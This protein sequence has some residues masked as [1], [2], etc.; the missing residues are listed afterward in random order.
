VFSYYVFSK[1]LYA[2]YDSRLLSIITFI[3]HNADADDLEKCL[4]D[5]QGLPEEERV[6]SEKYDRLQQSLNTIIDDFGMDYIYLVIPDPENGMMVNAISATSAA[7]REAGE[8][9]MPIWDQSDAYS[10]EELDRYASFWNAESI[11]YFEESSEWG[12][13]YT[14]CK[15]LRNTKGETVALICADLSSEYLHKE[16]NTLLIYS[17]LSAIIMIGLFG[18]I[19]IVWFRKKVT[20]PLLALENS[21]RNY[22]SKNK[23]KTDI[24]DFSFDMPYIRTDNEVQSL[25]EAINKM[26]IDM[27]TYAEEI[28]AKEKVIGEKELENLH[29]AEK[30]KAAAEIAELKGS[31]SALLANMPALTFSKDVESGQYIACN[32]AFAD[33]AHKETTEEIIGLTDRDIFSD[34]TADRIAEDDKKVLSMDKPYI[35]YEEVFD[36]EGNSRQVQTTK[37]KFTDPS[38]KLCILA[39]CLD[40]TEMNEIK[41]ESIWAKVAYEEA[42]DAS[43][44]YSNI[45]RALATDY[46]YLYYVDLKTDNFIEY[47]AKRSGEELG[48]ER[49]GE[50][51]FKESHRDAQVLLYADDL[52]AFAH[53]FTKE[54]ILRS[55]KKTGKFTLTYRMLIDNRPVY[56]NM[57]ATMMEN[58]DNHL[59][60]GVNNVDAQMKNQE[61]YERVVEERI[62]YSRITAL[63]GDYICIYTVDPT[64]D[65]FLEY[66]ATA[67]YEGLGLSKGGDNFFDEAIKE[68]ERTVCPEDR[69]R[70][71]N[72]FTKENILK[73]IKKSKIFILNYRLL[74]AGTP[75]YVCL[76]A[77]IVEEKGGPQLIIGVSNIDAQV[78]REEDFRRTLSMEK[79]KVNLDALTGVKNKHAYVDFEEELNKRIDKGDKKLRFAIVVF[80]VNDLKTVN[81]TYGHNRGDLLIKQASQIICDTFKHSPVFRVGGDEFAVIAQDRDYN[82]ID[83]L[84]EKIHECNRQNKGT[85]NAVV[86][87]GM[88][89][90]EAEK[91]VSAV[92]EKADVQMYENKKKLKK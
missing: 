17:I 64:T 84:V 19:I 34:E 35:F 71:A 72:A 4:A 59:I 80:D 36:R 28:I 13:F 70:F 21:T 57:K 65:H 45:A 8:T 20:N 56:Y 48:I 6:T 33:Y 81:D 10:I 82:D 26:A 49:K 2:D 86:A 3:E 90:F 31:V 32:R 25:G 68:S 18:F 1:A 91:N 60:I 42:R 78:K 92:F 88:A 46:D 44:T 66:S 61:E 12:A 77:A 83:K 15:P 30:A 54:N 38:G 75:V 55:I 89:R 40:I 58:D 11:N 27:Q 5:N 29:L 51:F 22:A 52:D 14:A 24:R 9:D 53:V 79:S 50:D 7:E 39:M 41:K 69:K 43:V 73:E 67:D 62:T 23:D 85:E 87:C 63:S 37:M 76:K 74:V 47:N 16:L